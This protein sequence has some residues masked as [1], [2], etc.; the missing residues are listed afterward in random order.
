MFSLT[1]FM[2]IIGQ[3]PSLGHRLFVFP[4]WTPRRTRALLLY[5]FVQPFIV[6]WTVRWWII[7]SAAAAVR[8]DVGQSGFTQPFFS[9]WLIHRAQRAS[10]PFHHEIYLTWKFG[11][12]IFQAAL[13]ANGMTSPP[14]MNWW[15]FSFS[16]S[17][18]KFVFFHSFHRASYKMKAQ[19]CTHKNWTHKMG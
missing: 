11:M 5:L 9:C 19:R 2:S 14:E 17:F 16:S 12:C 18:F 1:R 8:E 7:D 10:W 4:C 3:L 6:N 15:H 13:A